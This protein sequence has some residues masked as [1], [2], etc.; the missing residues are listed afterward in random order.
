MMIMITWKHVALWYKQTAM[1]RC[2]YILYLTKHYRMTTDPRF[3]QTS[4]YI[5]GSMPSNR[6]G[7]LQHFR[8][9]IRILRSLILSER[10]APFTMSMSFIRILVYLKKTMHLQSEIN[11]HKRYSKCEAAVYKNLVTFCTHDK[12]SFKNLETLF[13]CDP[14]FTCF[15]F[16][17]LQWAVKWVGLV[18]CCSTPLYSTTIV[19]GLLWG[20]FSPTF[21]SVLLSLLDSELI[22][23]CCII[24]L[25]PWTWSFSLMVLGWRTC[26]KGVIKFLLNSP[27][28]ELLT[29]L[30]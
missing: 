19:E 10:P 6:Y 7:W 17:L 24:T 14:R 16:S 25:Q 29:F 13:R 23:W 3:P 22:W 5:P 1:G 15:Q 21:L 20:K 27:N 11:E 4:Q 8:S 12:L 28:A 30:E 26:E 2:F 9:C 18:L